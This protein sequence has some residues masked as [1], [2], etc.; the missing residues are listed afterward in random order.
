MHE[1]HRSLQTF[2][3]KSQFDCHHHQCKAHPQSPTQFLNTSLPIVQIYLH[4]QFRWQI[5]SLWQPELKEIWRIDNLL[6]PASLLYVRPSVY[7]PYILNIQF[8]RLSF[9]R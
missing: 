6:F 8:R 1:C 4:S 7:P 3:Y 9:L 2:N 5:S